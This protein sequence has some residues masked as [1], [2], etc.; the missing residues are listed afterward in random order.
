MKFLL[1]TN[2]CIEFLNG[3]SDSLTDA[4]RAHSPS[5][6]ALCSIVEAEL[7]FGALNSD[8]V[9]ENLSTLERF[10]EPFSS[11]P[12]DKDAA[13]HYGRIRAHLSAAGDIIG[14]NDLQIAAIARANDLTLVTHNVDE[15]E[16]VPDLDIEDWQATRHR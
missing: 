3:T 9:D 10:F 13:R 2:A 4:I 8:R 12:F 1:D 11:L 16:R 14:P 7:L 6:I 5:E 15:F